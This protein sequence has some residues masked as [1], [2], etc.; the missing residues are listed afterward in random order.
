MRERGR[1]G[2]RKGGEWRSTKCGDSDGEAALI[3]WA[4][5][6]HLQHA[7][8]G[9]VHQ[10]CSHPIAHV[11][12]SSRRPKLRRGWQPC[13]KVTRNGGNC[14]PVSQSFSQPLGLGWS[15]GWSSTPRASVKTEDMT[16]YRNMRIC[17]RPR[18]PARPPRNMF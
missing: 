17:H 18:T 4:N 16:D 14:N 9:D 10:I 1:G 7:L 15:V 8:H 3:S 11:D 12:R 6:R 13:L 5:R 2:E